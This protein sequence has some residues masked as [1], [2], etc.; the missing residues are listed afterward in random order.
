MEMRSVSVG[1]VRITASVRSA[2]SRS[3]FANKSVATKAPLFSSTV[4]PTSID[5]CGQMPAQNMPSVGWIAAALPACMSQV[6]RP[7]LRLSRTSP[8]NGSAVKPLAAGTTSQCR[9]RCIRPTRPSDE[10]IRRARRRDARTSKR[11]ARLSSEAVD[12][13]AT[14][15][16]VIQHRLRRRATP[17]RILSSDAEGP[18]SDAS[19]RTHRSTHRST[20]CSTHWGTHRTPE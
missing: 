8:P 18:V 11:C 1:S 14:G 16:T 13:A 6:P 19:S 15:A 5:P 12:L 3:D 17:S 9:N 10:D 2:L 20:H 4:P 7:E